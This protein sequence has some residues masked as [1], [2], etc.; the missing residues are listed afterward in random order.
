MELLFIYIL[1]ELYEIS[2][3]KDDSMM[4]M[5]LRMDKYFK[6]SVLLFLIMHPTFYFAIYLSMITDL[7][8]VSLILI[9]LKTADIATKILLLEQVF[10][11]RSLSQEMALML[12]T[13]LHPLLPYINLLIYPPLVYMMF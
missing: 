1:L 7:S 8:T 5:L 9:F 13:P 2:W 4:K 10:V 3:Q 11:K 12:L 6:K